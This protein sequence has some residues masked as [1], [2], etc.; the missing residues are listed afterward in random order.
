MIKIDLFRALLAQAQKRDVCFVRLDD[1]AREHLRERDRI[2]VG[3][4]IQGEVDG[5]SGTLA[6]QKAA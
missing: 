6:V 4:L 5:R 3:E 1:L 2:P